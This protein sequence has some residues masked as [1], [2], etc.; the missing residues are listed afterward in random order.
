MSMP[1]Y[2]CRLYVP[3]YSYSPMIWRVNRRGKTIGFGQPTDAN[4][5]PSTSPT[6]SRTA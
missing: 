6:L 2:S 3:G 1:A 5:W 4:T